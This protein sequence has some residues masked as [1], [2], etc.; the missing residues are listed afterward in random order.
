M[1]LFRAVRA[2]GK[3]VITVVIAGRPMII[4]EVEKESDA[5]VI[6]LI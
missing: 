1:R 5:N 2:K 4:N 6:K 3:K